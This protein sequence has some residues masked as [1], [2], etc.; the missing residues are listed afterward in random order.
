MNKKIEKRKENITGGDNEAELTNEILEV[1]LLKGK[2]LYF[3]IF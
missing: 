1:Y 3:G 2:F